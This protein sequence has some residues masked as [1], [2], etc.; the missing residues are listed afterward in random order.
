[1]AAVARARHDVLKNLLPARHVALGSVN[2]PMQCMLK[3]V[4][5]QCLQLLR[6]PTTGQTRLIFSCQNQDQSLDDIDFSALHQR[7]TQNRLEECQTMHWLDACVLED[8]PR[9]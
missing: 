4:C 6:D 8:L 9:S 2:S 3:G 1:M 7:L 5:G